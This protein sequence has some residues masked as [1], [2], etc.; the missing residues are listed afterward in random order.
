M[1]TNE[2][3]EFSGTLKEFNNYKIESGL[4]TD[5]GGIAAIS[6]PEISESGAS[7]SARSPIT[8]DMERN[9]EPYGDVC[10]VLQDNE[11]MVFFGYNNKTRSIPGLPDGVPIEVPLDYGA[12][13]QILSPVGNPIP[14]APVT[15]FAPGMLGYAL[16]LAAFRTTEDTYLGSWKCL[17]GRAVINGLPEICTDR[18]D[19]DEGGGGGGGEGGGGGGGGEG[20]GAPGEG[21][22]ACKITDEKVMDQIWRYANRTVVAQI[23]LANNSFVG[24]RWTP[25]P[26]NRLFI[27]KRGAIVLA[28]LRKA[29]VPYYNT[30][31]CQVVAAGCR[32]IKIDKAKIR[33]IFS[34]LYTKVPK[35]L[36]SLGKDKVKRKKYL[37]ALLKKLPA[38][39]TSCN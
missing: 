26:S 30:Y 24:K 33:V 29:V 38:E 13:N 14:V 36:E 31:T 11:E 21:G 8:I 22:G 15:L 20:G 6:F 4:P 23:E 27:T 10:R 2:N 12:L 19:D 34:G 28:A 18:G 37:E 35:G 17:G 5:P 25:N 9:V 39:V 32:T 7:L 1:I 16:P 3:G